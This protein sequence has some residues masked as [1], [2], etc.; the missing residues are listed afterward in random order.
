MELEL[1]AP[2]ASFGPICQFRDTFTIRVCPNLNASWLCSRSGGPG[3]RAENKLQRKLSLLTCEW[4]CI[5]TSLSRGVH[6]CAEVTRSL[7]LVELQGVA[8]SLI[9]TIYDILTVFLR[10]DRHRAHAA[11][12]SCTSCCTNGAS[13]NDRSMLLLILRAARVNRRLLK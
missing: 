6:E 13:F 2:Y 5:E 10:W 7:N 4:Y 9:R 12:E 11:V 1:F 3:G 8:V